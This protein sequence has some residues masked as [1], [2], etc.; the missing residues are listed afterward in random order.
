MNNE[1]ALK[2]A[3]YLLDIKAVKLNIET[4]FTWASGLKSP[5]YCD[6]RV[7]LS[8]HIIRTYIRESFVN[9]ILDKFGSVDMI[10]GVATGGIP[11]G[12]LVAQN[13]GVPF[14][15][16]RASAKSHGLTNKIEGIVHEGQSAVVIEDLVSTGKSSLNAVKALRDKGCNIK[17]M[18]AIFTYGLDIAKENFEKANCPLFTLTNYDIL[19]KKALEEDYINSNDLQSLIKWR[20][21]PA[22]WGK[23]L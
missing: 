2:T 22:E 6:N 19:I 17:G 18:L 20:E 13:L 12:I 14:S 5:I 4:P 11:Q 21:N 3:S 15:Y 9:I 23:N 7:T 16:V 8:Y 1:I 10:A